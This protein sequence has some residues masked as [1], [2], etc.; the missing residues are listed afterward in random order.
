MPAI[1]FSPEFLDA[2]LAGTKCQT[3]RRP[4][5]RFRE[6]M[7]VNA[8]TQQRKAI[9]HKPPRNLTEAGLAEMRRM[10]GIAKKNYPPVP[11]VPPWRY[12]AH[13]LGRFIITDVAEFHPS[14]VSPDELDEWAVL[15]GFVD[16]YYADAW[17]IEHHGADWMD[18]SYTWI[19]W[20][21]LFD[22][23]FEP[24]EAVEAV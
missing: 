18:F 9:L 6:G 3:T 12:P 16:F 10:R 15:D 1:S 5:N 14:L 23:Y 2:I 7:T 24:L 11:T 19:R 13:F 4:T 20:G 17:F 22:R 8:Y 21:G